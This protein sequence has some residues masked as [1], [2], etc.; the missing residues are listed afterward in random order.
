MPRP[1]KVA[2]V[3]EI[4]EQLAASKA[5]FVTDYRGLTVAQ[6]TRLRRKLRESGTEYTVVKNTLT[7]IAA[8]ETDAQALDPFLEGPT[9]LAFAKQD[10]VAAA[11]ALLDFAKES[12]ILQIRGGVLGGKPVGADDIQALANLPPREVLLAQVVGGL[13][14]PISGFVFVLQ[15]TLR[16]LVY[17]LDAVRQKKE[18]AA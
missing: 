16:K 2:A 7:R 8:R 13:Q 9:A 3:E 14:A 15:G 6:M 17:A 18:S 5:V 12:K 4:R 1:E 11:K 10:P